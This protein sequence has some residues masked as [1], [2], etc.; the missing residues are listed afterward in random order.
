M[1]A[2]IIQIP[3]IFGT[4]LGIVTDKDLLILIVTIRIRGIPVILGAN[5]F[6]LTCR[7]LFILAI[8]IRISQIEVILGAGNAI[9]INE[10]VFI[11]AVLVRIG[12]IEV[13]LGA[14]CLILAGIDVFFDAVAVGVGLIEVI[15]GIEII[16]FT[17]IYR[18]VTAI[19]IDISHIVQDDNQDSIVLRC[20]GMQRIGDI[21]AILM[22]IAC[23]DFVTTKVHFAG[24]KTPVCICCQGDFRT[25][26]QIAYC[27]RCVRQRFLMIGDNCA[28]DSNRI[29]R[30][31]R[32]R[33]IRVTRI[34]SINFIFLT[35]FA[36]NH[37]DHIL[38]W[39][40]ISKFIIPIAIRAGFVDLVAIHVLED[41]HR[42]VDRITVRI[43]DIAADRE[44]VCVQ[45]RCDRI[46]WIRLIAAVRC[47]D[48]A[49]RIGDC[50]GIV[51]ICGNF[52]TV[53]SVFGRG[54]RPIAALARYNDVC[55]FNRFTVHI[56]YRACNYGTAW[57]C[58]NGFRGR[59]CT[60]VAL[61]D[62]FNHIVCVFEIRKLVISIFI[63]IYRLQEGFTRGVI[64][65]DRC[66]DIGV[67][68]IIQCITSDLVRS[69]RSAY[70]VGLGERR[71]NTIFTII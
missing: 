61:G 58:G 8:L 47:N 51:P 49:V 54:H 41:N 69:S 5:R 70:S 60:F 40:H 38:T 19:A 24:I 45:D 32:G 42:I 11:F 53:L 52:K 50:H 13:I 20:G 9:T 27:N 64:Q 15:L 44:V 1:V 10:N 55:T 67:F 25:G 59:V 26:I 4:W 28:A 39:T 30:F 63:G 33:L 18:F 14:R 7:D 37:D 46:I 16:I 17:R 21:G 2:V 23:N 62:D 56:C 48:C 3:V 57:L 29:L 35:I 68:A 6:I 71:I 31:R 34:T 43:M 36:R 12:Q 66:M 22:G 65:I